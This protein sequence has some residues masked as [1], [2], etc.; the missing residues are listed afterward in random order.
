M[1]I[2]YEYFVPIIKMFQIYSFLLTGSWL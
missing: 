2:L 1:G